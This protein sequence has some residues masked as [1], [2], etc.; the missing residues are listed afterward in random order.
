MIAH[1]LVC[2]NRYTVD[3]SALRSGEKAGRS[4]V[5]DETRIV[6]GS[7]G[8]ALSE[9]STFFSVGL[10]PTPAVIFPRSDFRVGVRC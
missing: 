8:E 6:A 4:E 5:E 1:S 10:V 3:Y 9:P 7:C 2:G